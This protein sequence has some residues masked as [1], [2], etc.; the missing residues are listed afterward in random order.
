MW[1]Y[2][3][4][5]NQLYYAA[6]LTMFLRL[7]VIDARAALTAPSVRTDAIRLYLLARLWHFLFLQTV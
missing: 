5:E 7:L 1:K 2:V 4:V 6:R 3:L